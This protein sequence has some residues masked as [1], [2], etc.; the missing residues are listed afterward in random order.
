MGLLFY[1]RCNIYL[2]ILLQLKSSM[3]IVIK[4]NNRVLEQDT[5][6]DVFI[7][8]GDIIMYKGIYYKKIFDIVDIAEVQTRFIGKIDTHRSDT[9]GI[10]G[11]YIT[12]LFIWDNLNNEWCKILDYKP[13][14]T[15]YFSYPHLLMLP[16][17]YYNYKPIYN[18]HT[19]ENCDLN[20]YKDITKTFSLHNS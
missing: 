3:K 19:C 7:N 6:N 14:T 11:I 4:N 16:G 2:K 17:T 20:N 10:S 1:K 13:P 12:P 5:I 15:K 9:N 8:D 18:L